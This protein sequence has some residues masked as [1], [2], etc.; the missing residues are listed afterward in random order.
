MFVVFSGYNPDA[1][2][3][4]FSELL[5]YNILTQKWSR[6]FTQNTEKMPQESVSNAVTMKDDIMVVSKVAN[7]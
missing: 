5:K 2:R 6:V 1:D 3:N 7:D 4:L